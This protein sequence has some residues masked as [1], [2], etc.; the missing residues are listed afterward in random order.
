MGR[1]SAAVLLLLISQISA[2]S[3]QIAFRHAPERLPAGEPAN[4]FVEVTGNESIDGFVLTLPASW[5]LDGIRIADDTG[6]STNFT[7]EPLVEYANR[8][9][10]VA[11]SPMHRSAYLILTVNPVSPSGASTATVTPVRLHHADRGGG[12]PRVLDNLRSRVVLPVVSERNAPI[13]RSA[14]FSPR[15]HRPAHDREAAGRFIP[16]DAD[17]VPGPWDVFT[18]ETWL[19]TTDFEQIVLSTWTGRDDDPYPFELVIDGSGHIV[20]YQGTEDHH[21]SM[22]SARPVADGSW[23]HVAL[24]HDSPEGWTRLFVDGMR[25]DSLV[26]R[27]AMTFRQPEGLSLGSRVAREDPDGDSS[28][29]RYTGRLDQLRIWPTARSLED[30]RASRMDPR[31]VE[32]KDGLELTFDDDSGASLDIPIAEDSPFSQRGITDLSVR[33]DPIGVTIAWTAPVSDALAYEVE[34]SADGLRY[35]PAG[36]LEAGRPAGASYSII[37]PDPVDGVMYYRIRELLPGGKERL[38]DAVKVGMGQ[39]G[40]EPSVIL[41]GN[42]PNPFNPTTRISYTVRET[43][44]VQVSVWDLSGQRISVLVDRTVSPGYHEVTF[45]ADTLPSGPYFVRLSTSEGTQTHQMVL[46]K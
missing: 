16:F 4:L 43:Q 21:V 36:R 14:D 33:S 18:V 7:T 28:S 31:S 29:T 15:A 30:V 12:E 6:R 2:A 44:Y 22:K 42:F 40:E 39:S 41:T 5:V 35:V 45:D 8:W 9:L 17:R 20:S 25:A 1:L 19:K 38:S 3:A 27:R 34:R 13:G 37:D 24:V 10:I 46:M 11:D 26:H 23:H 32:M